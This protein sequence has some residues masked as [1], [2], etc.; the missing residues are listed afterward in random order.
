M[1]VDN[2]RALPFLI[3]HL[4]SHRMHQENGH[5]AVLVARNPAAVPRATSFAER[6]GLPIAV[7]HGAKVAESDVNDGRNS[8]P[9]LP[10]NK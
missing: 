10:E 6:L 9:P 5:R 2:L 4:E 3:K 7:V 8:P 1:P